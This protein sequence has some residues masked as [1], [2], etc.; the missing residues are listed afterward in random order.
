MAA[1]RLSMRKI[2]EVLRLAALGHSRRAIGRIAGISHSTV[3][4][5]LQA[6]SEAG[7]S[8]QAA[9][10]LTEAELERRLFPPPD[11]PAGAVPLS[12]TGDRLLLKRRVFHARLRRARRDRSQQPRVGNSARA[13]AAA[14]S[15]AC[16]NCAGDL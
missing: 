7:L 1:E 10:G 8:V 16:S 14:R 15:W 4:L 12:W 11:V 13:H 6:A 5:Y 2:K 3:G 9:E